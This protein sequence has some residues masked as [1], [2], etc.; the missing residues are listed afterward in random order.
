MW[1]NFII[2]ILACPGTLHVMATFGLV[3]E[4]WK[5]Q[6]EAA[7][8][9]LLIA[10]VTGIIPLFVPADAF[11]GVDENYMCAELLIGPILGLSYG[12]ILL[13]LVSFPMVAGFLGYISRL[14]PSRQRERELSLIGSSES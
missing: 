7:F 6:F 3:L 2:L 1:T 12:S 8:V 13:C 9:G 10:Y 5:H 11:A 4:D 14:R